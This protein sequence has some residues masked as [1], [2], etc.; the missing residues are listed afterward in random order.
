[1]EKARTDAREARLNL[2]KG[3]K[4]TLSFKQAA[5]AYLEKLEEE[6]GK[7]LVMKRRRFKY[8]LVPALGNRALAK[9]TTFL[10]NRYKK[11]RLKEGGAP[12]TINRELAVLSHMFT[13]GVEWT[14]LDHRSA[15]IERLKEGDGRITFSLGNQAV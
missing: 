8:H 1:M 3:R 7:D 12:G 9:I 11:D 5:D 13:K 10:V 15:K 6:G 4:V 14:W 2:S